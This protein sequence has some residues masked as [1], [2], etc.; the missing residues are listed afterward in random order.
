MNPANQQP[1]TAEAY[2]NRGL[3]KRNGGDLDAALSDLD[4]AIELKPSL[5]QAYTNRSLVKKAKGD[6]AGAEADSDKALELQPD[7]PEVCHRR[8]MRRM[9]K[10]DWAGAISHFN[11]AIELNPTFAD[12][13][14]NRGAA[15]NASDDVNGALADFDRALEF[16]P[17][18]P[19][20]KEIVRLIKKKAK[21]A[22]A[23]KSDADT[24][25][26][27]KLPATKN[28]LALRTD[29]SDEALWQKLCALI[30]NMDGEF[31]VNLDFIS[32]SKYASVR[33]N[34]LASLVSD[35][36]KTFA[37]VID[38]VALSNPENPIL[39]VDLRD[40]P[41]RTFRVIPSALWAV[42]NNLSIANMSFG[43]FTE[44]DD[45]EGIFRGFMD[46]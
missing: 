40:E 39:V 30:Q 31:R 36:S 21:G 4:K 19:A 27:V 32:D 22:S 20:I 25:K 16:Q 33:A 46:S 24:A 43:E 9:K 26:K 23:K 13:Y 37:F 44:A 12:A 38:Q 10:S 1:Q 14:G 15:K 6:L 2:N 42:E 29:F 41:G 17:N 8:G 7:S 34:Q 35:D 11:R 28:T 5:W 18:S 45:D 3:A